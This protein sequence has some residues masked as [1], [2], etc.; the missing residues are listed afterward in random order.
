MRIHHPLLALA[1]PFLVAAI[2]APAPPTAAQRAAAIK[3]TTPLVDEM[4][5]TAKTSKDDARLVAMRAQ[6]AFMPAIRNPAIHDPAA[7]ILQARITLFTQSALDASAAM[8][9]LDECRRDFPNDAKI[10]ELQPKIKKLLDADIH[11]FFIKNRGTLRFNLLKARTGDIDAIY[12]VAEAYA[13]GDGVL[14]DH[15]EA[16]RY[17]TF[18]A[19]A[20][21][22][23]AMASMAIYEEV[24]SKILAWL[25]KSFAAGHYAAADSIGELYA[26]WRFGAL[27]QHD[28]PKDLNKAFAWY[29]LSFHAGVPGSADDLGKLLNEKD[30]SGYDPAA[31]IGYWRIGAEQFRSD[32]I[33]ALKDRK[34]GLLD[35]GFSFEA[36]PARPQ[37]GKPLPA[38]G[39]LVGL[40]S[41]KGPANGKIKYNDIITEVNGKPFSSDFD[42][43][44][45][46]Y[47]STDGKL[48]FKLIRGEQEL[49]TTITALNQPIK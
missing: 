49:T 35:V 17:Y 10:A 32:S 5:A 36:A 31:A 14:S 15:D 9:M 41:E 25:E 16:R 46:M 29:R 27:K 39:A 1:L 3:A 7:A 4:E 42:F 12:E 18:A 26:G 40:V 43:R 22:A 6:Q 8:A 13:G 28:V 38:V 21:H 30:F 37:F 24:D 11:E 45:I 47:M 34:L 19:A 44:Q 2:D 23:E 20:G 48:T 33:K